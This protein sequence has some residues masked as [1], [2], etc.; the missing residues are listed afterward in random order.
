MPKSK[1]KILILERNESYSNYLKNLFED[2]SHEAVAV[3]DAIDAL[4]YLS[5]DESR[6]ISLI[7]LG[8]YL[9]GMDG[10]KFLEEIKSTKSLKNIP[11]IIQSGAS[12][13]QLQR[14]IALGADK[15]LQKPYKLEDLL[16]A[17]EELQPKILAYERS[18]N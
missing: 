5:S 7:I 8:I 2:S 18:I 6:G 4:K 13:E 16:S 9:P 3:T 11:T 17:T 15:Y 14:G 12:Y 1:H 10:L